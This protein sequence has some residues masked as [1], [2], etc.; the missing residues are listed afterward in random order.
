MTYTTMSAPFKASFDEFDVPIEMQEGFWNYFMY[1]WEPGSFGMAILRN[2]FRDAVCRAHPAL[3]AEHL[4][5]IARWFYNVRLPDAYG[6]NEKIESWMSLTNEQ[7]REIME[8]IRLCPTV[9][10]I[11][12]TVPGA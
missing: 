10:D 5:E 3:S 11:L 8:D 4:R 1:G 2:D 6:S 12:R 9:F 7:R